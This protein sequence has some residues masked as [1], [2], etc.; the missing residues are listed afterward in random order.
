MKSSRVTET[1]IRFILDGNKIVLTAFLATERDGSHKLTGA[2]LTTGDTELFD[3]SENKNLQSAR[4]I[5]I[6]YNVDQLTKGV[7]PRLEKALLKIAAQGEKLAE[8]NCPANG[9]RMTGNISH[10]PRPSGRFLRMPAAG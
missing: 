8:Q 6:L 4:F 1:S 10:G 7:D 2:F 3:G 5:F 9:E